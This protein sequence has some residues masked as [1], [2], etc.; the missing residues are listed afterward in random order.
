MS[1]PLT[2]TV[3]MPSGTRV[4]VDPYSANPVVDGFKAQSPALYAAALLE[5]PP[6][7]LFE[8]GDL[9]P[10]TTSGVDTMY[11]TWVPF[12][13]RHHAAVAQSRGEVLQLIEDFGKDPSGSVDSDG[14]SAYLRRVSDWLTGRYVERPA[15]MSAAPDATDPHNA[16]GLYDAIFGAQEAALTA[17]H[18][19]VLAAQQAWNEQRSRTGSYADGFGR[20][21]R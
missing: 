15:P 12:G 17:R 10:F 5:G 2:A 13:V 4:A 9:P 3:T 19:P 8:C 20:A 11:L 6:P 18:A 7:T 14:L 1:T 16:P 21:Q